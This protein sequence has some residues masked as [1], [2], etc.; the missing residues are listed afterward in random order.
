[1][2]IFVPC[3][4][5]RSSHDFFP[6]LGSIDSNGHAWATQRGETCT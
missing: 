1:M 2:I 4:V 6:Y 5:A 3:I